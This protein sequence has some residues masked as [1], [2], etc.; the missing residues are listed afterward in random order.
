MKRLVPATIL[1]IFII[2]ICAASNY[3]ICKSIKI[4]KG[5]IEKCEQLYKGEKFE[6]AKDCAKKFKDNWIKS[7]RL[8]SVYSNHCPLDDITKLSGILPVAI[9]KKNDFEF[10]SSISQL[11]TAFDIIYEEQSFTLQSLY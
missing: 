10:A 1:L 7:N 2:I 4:A 9:D 5:E 6:D 11:K 8:I 3:T